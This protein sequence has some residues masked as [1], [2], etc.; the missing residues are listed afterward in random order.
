MLG[1]LLVPRLPVSCRH[2][3][4][5]SRRY[6]PLRSSPG[7]GIRNGLIQTDWPIRPRYSAW[8]D[9]RSAQATGAGARRPRPGRRD[10]RP[11]RGHRSRRMKREFIQY[12]SAKLGCAGHHSA[13]RRWRL[14]IFTGHPRPAAARPRPHC[15]PWAPRAMMAD[16][17]VASGR[18]RSGP[19]VAPSRKPPGPCRSRRR[20]GPRWSSPR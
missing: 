16:G 8:G 3:R 5:R 2:K 17:V 14:P 20:P 18:A 13:H 11:E 9:Y 4:W 15:W 6:S 1:G 10:G 7:H 12:V 19:P